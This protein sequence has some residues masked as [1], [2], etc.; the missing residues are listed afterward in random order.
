MSLPRVRPAAQ[1][2]PAVESE[3]DPVAK[4]TKS[5][6]GAVSKVKYDQTYQRTSC[7]R[8]A[9]GRGV[10]S[11]AWVGL[12]RDMA[13]R[14]TTLTWLASR[15]FNHFLL[16]AVISGRFPMNDR[17]VLVQVIGL[18]FKVGSVR[19]STTDFTKKPVV[20]A[21][22]EDFRALNADFPLVSKRG[23]NNVIQAGINQYVTAVENY[24]TYG[25]RDLYV[26][27]LK[28]LSVADA[29]VVALR[30]LSQVSWSHHSRQ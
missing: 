6:D 25:L 18:C 15:A 16:S 11:P 23:M 30:V 14:M 28:A 20:A 19:I 4:K 12:F 1:K 29:E 7:V 5:A 24:L 9:I 8:I 13:K 17:N 21:W 10:G 22:I 26:R 3:T 2:R 27:A